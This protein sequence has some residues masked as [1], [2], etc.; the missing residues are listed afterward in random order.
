MSGSNDDLCSGLASG[1]YP[2]SNS[3][4]PVKGGG[5]GYGNVIGYDLQPFVSKS[6]HLQLY[7]VQ[8]YELSKK[9]GFGSTIIFNVK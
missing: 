1:S 6:L 3:L 5:G 8:Q 9:G 7:G 2:T 4:G